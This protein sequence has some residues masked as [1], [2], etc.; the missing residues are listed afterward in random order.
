[1]MRRV[2]HGPSA[3]ASQQALLRWGVALVWLSTALLVLHPAYRA[4]G[5]AWL[6]RLGLPSA[7]M[8]A[9]CAAELVLG[10]RVA[11]GAPT[12][13]L[14]WLQTVLVLGFS[15]ILAVMEPL[16]LAHPFGVLSKNLP[17]LAVVWV[18]LRVHEEGWSPATLW[19]LR[20][21]MAIVWITEGLFP[22][23]LFQQASELAVV[24]GSGLVSGDPGVFLAWM[25]AAQVLSGVAALALR[26]RLLLVLLAC[27]LLALLVL[28]LLVSWQE[29]LLWV[30]PFGPMTK[31]LPILA[32]TLVLLARLRAQESST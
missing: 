19:L 27:Q 22:K 18:G 7:L 9:T 14:A 1:M 20:I 26:G 3:S 24:A 15:V 30:H 25:G 5:E 28:P 4:E 17:L 29:P 11:L 10:S 2:S 23:I 21:G 31:N 6:A 32:G 13:A 8:W 16:L 12:R